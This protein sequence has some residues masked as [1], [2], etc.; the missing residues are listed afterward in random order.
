MKVSDHLWPVV[1]LRQDK[2]PKILE[3][4]DLGKG[5]PIGCDIHLCPRPCLLLY[6]AM[7]L[8]LLFPSAKGRCEVLAVEGLV[9]H[10]H[11]TLGA[12]GVGSFLFLHDHDCVL[13]VA[14]HKV[15]PGVVPI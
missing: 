9:L 3:V 14:V 15:N 1:V 13:H 12:P 2:S 7:P 10:I 8:P 4:G 6:Q 11:V 5:D